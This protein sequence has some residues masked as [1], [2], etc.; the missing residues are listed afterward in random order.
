MRRDGEVVHGGA[1]DLFYGLPVPRLDQA[2]RREPRAADAGDI[3]LGQIV[4]SGLAGDAACG[5]KMHLR[6]GTGER[7]QHRDPA[8]RRRRE[9]L[10]MVVAALVRRHQFRGGGDAGKIGD[11]R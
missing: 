5:A 11:G 10:D 2:D 7:F 4:G 6:E 8:R 3:G 1:G 9:E